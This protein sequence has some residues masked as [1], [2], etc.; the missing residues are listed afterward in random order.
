MRAVRELQRELPNLREF[1][2]LSPVP[3]FRKWL[4]SSLSLA[5]RAQSD[6]TAESV[7]FD[8]LLLSEADCLV[9]GE[10]ADPTERTTS[11]A[12]TLLSG[13]RALEVRIV[14]P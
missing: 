6:L 5:I 11:S 10:L 3:G 2:T 12:N 13:L 8:S 4:I 1:S 7:K 14:V 9:L